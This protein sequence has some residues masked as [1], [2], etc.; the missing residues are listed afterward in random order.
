MEGAPWPFPTKLAEDLPTIELTEAVIAAVKRVMFI[1]PKVITRIEHQGI[2]LFPTK[3]GTLLITTDSHALAQVS[4]PISMPKAANKLVLPR[5][6]AE[7]IIAQCKTGTKLL[8]LPDYLVAFGEGVELYSNLLGNATVTDLPKMVSNIVEGS[9][10]RISLPKD[11]SEAL[12]R[13]SLLAG[14]DKKAAITLAIKKNQLLLN[15]AFRFSEFTDAF[16]LEGDDNMMPVTIKVEL[17][18]LRKALDQAEEFCITKRALVLYGKDDFLCLIA[19][20]DK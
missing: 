14:E 4:V 12:K 1:E 7:Q 18:E 20:H 16:D 9:E 5:A 3:E 2:I 10:V 19:G 17:D 11:L 15:G 13:A 6:F 8:L